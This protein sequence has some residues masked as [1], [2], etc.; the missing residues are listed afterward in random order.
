MLERASIAGGATVAV[1]L[2]VILSIVFY[3]YVRQRRKENRLRYVT[4]YSSFL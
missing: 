1:I 2:V 4:K 3:T